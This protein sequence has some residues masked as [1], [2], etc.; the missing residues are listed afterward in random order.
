MAGKPDES[1]GAESRPRFEGDIK[2]IADAIA[3]SMTRFD[4]FAY[5][6]KPKTAK[7]NPS[8]LT[9]QRSMIKALHDLMPSMCFKKT[10][11]KKAVTSAREMKQFSWRNQLKPGEIDEFDTVIAARI[12]SLA[13]TSRRA[14]CRRNTGPSI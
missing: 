7:V 1:A 5:G 3:P 10:D 4:F 9:K 13:D 2:A 12:G 6:D 8:V 11:L 14:S